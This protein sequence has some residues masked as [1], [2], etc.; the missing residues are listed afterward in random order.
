MPSPAGL[1]RRPDARAESVEDLVEQVVRGEVRIPEFQRGLTW[2]TKDVLALFDSIYRGFPIGSLLFRRG[3]AQAGPLKIGPLDLFGVETSRALWVI[4]GQQRL[5]SLAAGLARPGPI[6]MASDVYVVYFDPAEQTFQAPPPHTGEIPSAWVPLPQLLS[7]SEL[8]EWMFSWP[9]NQDAALR[10]IVFEAGRRLREYRV[11]V[12]VIDTD[13]EGVLRTMFHRVNNSG[14]PLTW[15]EVYEALFGH[16]G[17][18]PS[19]LR[20]LATQL[21]TLGMGRPEVK[22]QL[23]PCL[24]A[25]RGLDV[26]RSFR[27]HLRDAPTI[28][29]G[30][31]SEAAPVLRE[32]LSFLR[33][34][35]EIPHLHLLPY[36]APLVV[37]T[38]F[39]KEH[40]EPNARTQTLL[41]R[42]IWRS[43][44]GASSAD[45]RALRRGGVAVISADEE[46]SLQVLL[47][48]VGTQQGRSGFEA[49]PFSGQ[50]ARS[51]IAMLGLVSLRPLHLGGAQLS[52]ELGA[53]D[54]PAR[55]EDSGELGAPV[56]V[57]ML[58]RDADRDAFLPMVPLGG[59]HWARR[60]EGNRLLLPG[61]GSAERELRAF[62]ERHG[63]THP[64][65]ESH[66]INP[67]CAAALAEGDVDRAAQVR[68]Q[69][70][71]GLIEQLGSRLAGWGQ[72]D[73]PSIEYLIAQAGSE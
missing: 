37:L 26:T 58:I 51:R 29:D 35:A 73:R 41:V 72:S 24:L 44:L 42:W 17:K 65:L 27:E 60:S 67:A 47:K 69:A 59:D 56:D 2:E 45:D 66:L 36:T 5:T 64:V 62:I 68:A 23:L 38:R 12:Y 71:E 43:F 6:W 39:F 55:S 31:A 32:V 8:S 30:A 21:E 53:A 34:K 70:F 3:P 57:A 10:S 40:P 11:P 33:T 18:H 20:E 7:S 61:H 54:G 49:Q 13:D 46:A 52:L 1:I 63:T 19:S 22:S 16:K 48:L 9:H 4:D 50:S 15:R 14:K 25:F 28:L